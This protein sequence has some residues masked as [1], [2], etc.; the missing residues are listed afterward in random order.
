MG[1]FFDPAC[2]LA[3]LDCAGAIGDVTFTIPGAHMIESCVLAF[4]IEPEMVA[5]TVAKPSAADLSNVF[6]EVRDFVADG[7]GVPDGEA[8]YAMLFNILHI[9]DPVGLLREACRALAP[10]GKAGIIHW[11][12]DLETPRGPSALIRPS[13]EQCRSWVSVR[14]SSSFAM[15]RLPAALGIGG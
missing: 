15:S 10:G 5:V 9:E 2:V 7:C 8:G 1:A 3:K 13:A 4:D 14:G 11:R 6:T 12:S